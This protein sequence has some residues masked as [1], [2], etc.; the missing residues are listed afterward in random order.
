MHQPIN[1]DIFTNLLI[2]GSC[3]EP[4]SKLLLSAVLVNCY[5]SSIRNLKCSA[6]HQKIVCVLDC[7]SSAGIWA[8]T[9]NLSI[10]HFQRNSDEIISSLTFMNSFFSFFFEAWKGKFVFALPFFLDVCIDRIL[11]SWERKYNSLTQSHSRRFQLHCL[12]YTHPTTTVPKLWIKIIA[13]LCV[14]AEPNT[15]SMSKS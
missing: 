14:M 2:F 11:W 12:C 1:L 6:Q 7:S 3:L 4:L 10:C 15:N 5:S 9:L 13:V 8:L